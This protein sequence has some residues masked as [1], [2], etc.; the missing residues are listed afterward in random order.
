[1]DAVTGENWGYTPLHMAWAQGNVA[2]VQA[3]LAAGADVTVVDAKG[4][5]PGQ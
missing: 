2:T 1:M 3:M 4:R 5:C